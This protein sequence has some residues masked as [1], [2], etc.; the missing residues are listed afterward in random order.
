MPFQEHS[1]I[2]NSTKVVYSDW[3]A[4]DGRP[5]VCVHGLTGN[6]F[7]FDF[8]APALVE[9]GYRVIAVDL[10][11]R[12]R[13]DFLSNPLDYNYETYLQNLGDLLTHLGLTRTDWLGVSLG[14]LLGMR[15][16]GEE[17]SPIERLIL[18][19][20]GPEVPKDALNFIYQVIKQPYYFE[21]VA[22]LEQRMRATRGLS[23]GPVTDEQWAHMAQHNARATD[24]GRVTYAY[25][26]EIA[27]VFEGEPLGSVDMWACW[28]A[29]ACPVMV[30]Q[31]GQ[32]ILLTTDIIENM[33][34]SGPAFDFQVFDDCGHVPS[35]MAEE[36]IQAVRGWLKDETN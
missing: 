19:D 36:Q 28:N 12:G 24:D 8:I 15:M 30:I 29:I 18:N 6:G 21:D 20:I 27:R 11:G 33:R 25:D 35:L 31:G 34:Q 23:W 10:P 4:E 26:A 32:S 2:S 13:S 16:A 17:N 14:G 22:E 5:I 1:F 3:G 7:D 9:D